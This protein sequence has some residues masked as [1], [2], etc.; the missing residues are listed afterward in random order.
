MNQ[1][2][3]HGEADRVAPAEAQVPGEHAALTRRGALQTGAGSVLAVAL[4]SPSLAAAPVDQSNTGHGP[5][6]HLSFDE[7][8]RF[9]RDDAPGAEV[10]AFN[11]SGWREVDLPHDWRIEDLPYATSDDGGATAD[12]SLFAFTGASSTDRTPPAA[13]GPFDRNG[14][15]KPDLDIENPHVGRIVLPGGRSQGYTV[16]GIGWY[17]KRF[18]VPAMAGTRASDQQVELCFDGVYRNADVWLNGV[19]L[20]FHPN[21]Y[22]SFAH[23]LTPHLRPDG[24]NI[25]AVRVDNVG[26]T[27]RWY[28]GS[29]IYRHTWLTVTGAVAVPRLG[30]HVTTPVV[31]HARSV[32]RV[33]VQV[34]S[35]GRPTSASVRIS[36]ID[37]SGRV[38]ATK[39]TMAQSV[40]PNA[41]ATHAAD[42]EI[43]DAALWSPESPSLYQVR[44]EVMVDGRT[45]DAVETRFGIR[46]L[47]FN[48][49]QGFLL[50]GKSYKIHGGNAHH[51]Y[52]ALGSAAID[53]AEVRRVEIMKAA[54][55]NAIRAAHNPSSPTF[56]EACDR[57][58]MF[59]YEEFSDVWDIPKVP[60]DYH[61]HFPEWWQRDLTEM[62]TRDRNHPSIIIWSIGNEISADPNKYGPRLAA[63]VRSLDTTRPIAQ[64]GMNVGPRGSD[65]WS[66]VDIGDFHSAPSPAERAAHRDKAFLQSED[67][68]SKIYDDWKLAANDPGYV[69]NWVWVGWDYIGE[70]GSGVPILARSREEAEKV[71]YGP[72]TGKILYPWFNAAQGDLDLIGQRRPQSYL[73]AVVNGISPLEVMVGRPTPGDL[74]QFNVGYSFYDELA[75][76]SW[77]VPIGKPMTV[78]VYTLG[79]S[80]TLLLNGRPAGTSAVTEADKRIATFMVPYA[81]GKLVAVASRGGR[82]LA[83]RTLETVGAAAAI[84]LTSDVSSLT[85]DR[86]DLAHVLVEVVDAKGRVVPDAVQKISFAIA[87]AGEL[88]G[89]ANGNP[90]NVDSFKRPR[91]W[92]WHGLAQAIV[93]PAKTSGRVLLMASGEGLRPARLALDVATMDTKR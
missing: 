42:L 51:D 65:I 92:T 11:D 26:K 53:R 86:G 73:R 47:V 32:A 46:S 63:L 69:G 90:H 89:V 30:V 2:A 93:R 56:I 25:L 76:W 28:T 35:A 41:V 7:G 83:R 18:R 88:V 29:G 14:D 70:A 39:T 58:G 49:E 59:L 54:G 66:Y 85:T 36:A 64:G 16:G 78:R 91:R 19:H 43:A 20:G 80:V 72:V 38:V 13:I 82:E 27:S 57:L 8:W 67:T 23:D 48:G 84:R 9:H 37:P 33:E 61:A 68:S 1:P 79:D 21:G 52:G 87:G 55:L 74:E 71:K 40:A 4:A 31:A 44:S 15:P 81:P 24:D 5:R 50:N 62:V 45:V 22:T 3:D 34:G 77:D 12:P 6:R 60:D 75:S 17:R 10:P